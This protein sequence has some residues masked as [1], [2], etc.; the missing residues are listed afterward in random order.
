MLFCQ[1]SVFKMLFNSAVLNA[2]LLCV[3]SSVSPL[4][5]LFVSQTQFVLMSAISFLIGLTEGCKVEGGPTS[6]PI[7]KFAQI[8]MA[9]EKKKCSSFKFQ[10]L[11]LLYLE[12][13]LKVAVL[14]LI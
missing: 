9:I 13:N 10:T 3:F 1:G 2:A 5:L 6:L 8:L 7:V 4:I 11:K 14:C 12:S